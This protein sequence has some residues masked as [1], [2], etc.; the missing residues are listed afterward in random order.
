MRKAFS[1]AELLI[2]VAIIGILA[3][4][5]MPYVQNH[6]EQ[7]RES[8]AKDNLRVFRE[9]IQFYAV[10]HNDL[11]PGYPGND[12]S[13]APTGDT[14][15][16]QMVVQESYLR[17]MPRNPFNDL[18]TLHIVGNADAFPA[19]GTGDHGWIYKPATHIIRIDW[20]GKDSA[21]IAFSTY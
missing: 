13:V 14:F 8:A 11:A 4:L 10:R 5:T 19:E 15:R 3:A 1:L 21:G 12:P 20:P 17:K 9:T 2:V 7:A 6:A 16:L 18:D